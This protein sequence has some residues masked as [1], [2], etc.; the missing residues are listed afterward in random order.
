MILW[1][2]QLGSFSLGFML[3]WAL[4]GCA[5]GDPA[6][7]FAGNVYPAE[8]TIAASIAEPAERVAMDPVLMQAFDANPNHRTYGA[9]ISGNPGVIFYD[10]TLR[11][12]LL[13]D[14]MRHEGC[15]ALRFHRTGEAQWH[16]NIQVRA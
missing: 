15:H 11:G 9:Y 2:H 13:D 5:E 7:D 14:V 16:G 10:E 1:R 4:L 3:C 6:T 12:W 8:C